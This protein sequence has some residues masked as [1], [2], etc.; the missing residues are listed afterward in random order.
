MYLIKIYNN[1]TENLLFLFFLEKI[2]NESENLLLS[3]K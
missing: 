3:C 2:H 1:A